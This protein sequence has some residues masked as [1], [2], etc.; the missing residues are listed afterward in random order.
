MQKYTVQKGDSLWKVS[1]VFGISVSE[2]ATVNNLNTHEEQSIIYPGQILIIPEKHKQYDTRLTIEL[3]NLRWGVYPKAHLRLTFDGEQHEYLTDKNGVVQGVLIDD[4]TKGIKVELN[5]FDGKGYFT[6]AYHRQLP[7]GEFRFRISSREMIF[8]GNT[9][10]AEGTSV[11]SKTNEKTRLENRTPGDGEGDNYKI[12]SA[13]TDNVD[14]GNEDYESNGAGKPSC[15]AG[16]VGGSENNKSNDNK[17]QNSIL[18]PPVDNGKTSEQINTRVEGGIPVQVN[19]TGNHEKGLRLPPEG[20]PYR[21]LILEASEKYGMAAEGIAAFIQA[22]SGWKANADNGIAVGLGQFTVPAWIQGSTYKKSKV[23]QFKE[24]KSISNEDI[25]K[26]RYK[27]EYSIDMI[28]AQYE[29]IMNMLGKRFT[30]LPSLTDDE[31]IKLMYFFYSGEA[32]AWDIMMN[33]KDNDK[34]YPKFDASDENYDYILRRQ[35]LDHQTIDTLYSIDN[36]GKTAF[37]AWILNRTDSFII[38]E[39]YRLE[40]IDKLGDT[41]SLGNIINRFNS[42]FNPDNFKLPVKTERTSDKSDKKAEEE[43]KK[44][45]MWSNPIQPHCRI[46]TKRFNPE[47]PHKA[48]F[49]FVRDGGHRAHQGV[50]I[51]ADAETPVYAVC[52]CHLVYYEFQR[53]YGNTLCIGVDVNDLTPEKQKLCVYKDKK[54][55]KIYFFYAHLTD[56]AD[57]INEYLKTKKKKKLFIKS[58]TVIGISGYTGN[59]GD[60]TPPMNS[61]KNGGHL[62]FEVRTKPSIAGKSGLNYRLDPAPFIDGFNYP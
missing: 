45:T 46:R 36:K 2:L 14:N 9:R 15:D 57:F 1:K 33:G 39:F 4:C 38:P 61:I 16:T 49:G 27:A 22:E 3:K 11:S 37:T 32:R 5:Q 24:N 52:D 56:A 25:L 29:H 41:I 20:E 58:N 8:Q 60:C 51:E 35:G 62:H 17:N 50:D 30:P 28:G 53:S 10:A 59:A 40:P 48:S 26:L 6:I 21:A 47:G 31:K 34:Y 19:P 12:N 18:V 13:R 23:Y 54:L 42:K 55:K 44:E 43:S 7:Q